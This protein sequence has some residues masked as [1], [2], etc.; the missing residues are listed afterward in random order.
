ML[1]RRDRSLTKK[2]SESQISKKT[3]FSPFELRW[4]LNN[5]SY[6]YYQ[7]ERIFNDLPIDMNKN[8]IEGLGIF[9]DFIICG[10]S[11]AINDIITF[12]ETNTTETNTIEITIK[13]INIDPI[14]ISYEIHKKIIE[15]YNKYKKHYKII[16]KY[17][18]HDIEPDGFYGLNSY[19]HAGGGKGGHEGAIVFKDGILYKKME[20]TDKTKIQITNTRSEIE[21]IDSE[22]FTYLLFY[23]LKLVNSQNN[24]YSILNDLVKTG[25]KLKDINENIQSIEFNI[26]NNIE[27]QTGNKYY[28]LYNLKPKGTGNIYDYKIGVFTEDFNEKK[29][30][31]RFLYKEHS[32]TGGDNELKKINYFKQAR[33]DVNSTSNLYGF[34]C[35]GCDEKFNDLFKKYMMYCDDTDKSISESIDKNRQTG[36]VF[37][38]GKRNKLNSTPSPPLNTTTTTTSTSTSSSNTTQDIHN[39]NSLFSKHYTEYDSIINPVDLD[40]DAMTINKIPIP[41]RAFY[42]YNKEGYFATLYGSEGSEGANGLLSTFIDNGLKIHKDI[43][44]YDA[45]FKYLMILTHMT[46]IDEF[47]VNNEVLFRNVIPKKSI[48]HKSYQ[49]GLKIARTISKATGLPDTLDAL[50]KKRNKFPLYGLHPLLTINEIL[51]GAKEDDKQKLLANLHKLITNV[52]L[53]QYKQYNSFKYHTSTDNDD[54][55]GVAFIGSSIIIND[56][57]FECN[58]IDFGHPV[59]FDFDKLNRNNDLHKCIKDIF[60]N[61]LFGG[62]SLYMFFFIHIGPETIPANFYDIIDA[63]FECLEYT[64]SKNYGFI[65]LSKT[66]KNTNI[67]RETDENTNTYGFEMETVENTNIKRETDE[68][69]NTY[70]FEDLCDTKQIVFETYMNNKDLMKKIISTNYNISNKNIEKILND[71]VAKEQ[72]KTNNNKNETC[73]YA[74]MLYMNRFMDILAIQDTTCVTNNIS[75]YSTVTNTSHTGGTRTNKRKLKTQKQAR[76][77]KQTRSH[78]RNHTKKSIKRKY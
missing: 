17:I 53:N 26:N 7:D 15:K 73:D 41:D 32:Q 35:E 58:L 13:N 63:F 56:D 62:L 74:K 21:K 31:A 57:T 72:Y 14:L 30:K 48:L 54:I 16:L 18:S 46:Y 44:T 29:N 4:S 76:T 11:N 59:F 55:M 66:D 61:F 78:I 67:K 12:S 69:I 70:G 20:D 42:A 49:A 1:R 77:H 37:G 38:F 24:K 52:F 71:K 10:N 33:I 39:N 36:G 50:L 27:N 25:I 6:R 68:N 9:N 65:K 22:L 60:M 47:S 40:A 3:K 64:Q 34:R 2:I 28:E 19:T 51:E 75:P 8:Y 23:V 5:K 45:K 43:K